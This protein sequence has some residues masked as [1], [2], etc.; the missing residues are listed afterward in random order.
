MPYSDS[1]QYYMTFKTE[2]N[3]EGH[4]I[5]F[6]QDILN[7]LKHACEF[8]RF[9]NNYDLTEHIKLYGETEVVD[10]EGPENV[11]EDLF[12][13]NMPDGWKNNMVDEFITDMS[14]QDIETFIN[15]I[16]FIKCLKLANDGGI[17]EEDNYLEA[18]LTHDGL[19]RFFWCVLYE[20]IEIADGV[21]EI[22]IPTW[23][24]HFGDYWDPNDPNHTNDTDDDDTDDDEEQIV[25]NPQR[26]TDEALDRIGGA[27][28]RCA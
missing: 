14:I 16:G 4:L 11:F 17:Y 19:R 18:L 20:M 1:N 6:N 9:L 27:V 5:A 10:T 23:Q 3:V 2:I 28:A 7:S 21:A 22:N 8:E 24:V 25:F 26:I 12:G 15:D 13:Y